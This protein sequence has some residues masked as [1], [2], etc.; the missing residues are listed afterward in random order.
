MFI[1]YMNTNLDASAWM[2]FET[3]ESMLIFLEATVSDILEKDKVA[4]N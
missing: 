2:P 1:A 4:D 3:I